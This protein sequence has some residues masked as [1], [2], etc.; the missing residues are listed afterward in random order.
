MSEAFPMQ[1]LGEL[2]AVRP[3]EAT[4]SHVR[5]PDWE[6]KLTGT[7]IAIGP[8]K[9]LR[10]GLLAPMSVAPGDKI[11]FGAAVG[12]ESSFNGKPLRIMRD[13]EIDVVLG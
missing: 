6:R 12:M 2:V 11:I 13:S 1:L 8:G 7:V 10:P 9:E 4:E 5:V 3:D